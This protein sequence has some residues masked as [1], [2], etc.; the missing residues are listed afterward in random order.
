M[1]LS[2]FAEWITGFMAT[3]R[4]LASAGK[5]VD[6]RRQLHG[7]HDLEQRRNLVAQLGAIAYTTG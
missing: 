3:E 7:E 6:L 4:F 5:Y 1:P 2:D